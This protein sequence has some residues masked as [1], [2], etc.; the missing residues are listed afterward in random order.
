MPTQRTLA[1][2]QATALHFAGLPKPQ[3]PSEVSK[4]ARRIHD[5]K[6]SEEGG[7]KTPLDIPPEELEELRAS[8]PIYSVP[9][10]E[11]AGDMECLIWQ[12]A[13]KRGPY[14]THGEGVERTYLAEGLYLLKGRGKGVVYTQ[15]LL[16]HFAGLKAHPHPGWTLQL[17]CGCLHCCNPKHL[18]AMSA[19]QIRAAE[20]ERREERKARKE[21]ALEEERVYQLDRKPAA[22]YVDPLITWLKGGEGEDKA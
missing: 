11:E 17:G 13:E 2:K 15:D 19:L 3:K 1:Q 21:L 18:V 22:P 5:K 7:R 4:R 20:K 14:Q 10:G 8:W 12:G 6:L 9:L 16:I